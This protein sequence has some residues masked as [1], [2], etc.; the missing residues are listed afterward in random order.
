VEVVYAEIAVPEDQK[1]TSTHKEEI[2][3]SFLGNPLRQIQHLLEE[4]LA[5]RCLSKSR[6]VEIGNFG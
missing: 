6:I 3:S 4:H 5:K 2:P 1:L